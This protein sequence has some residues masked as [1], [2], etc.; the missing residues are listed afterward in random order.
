MVEKLL[1][2]FKISKKEKGSFRY[3]GLNV[4]QMGKE[5]FVDQN[6]YISSLKPVQLSTERVPQ[7]DEE[8]TIEA[9][10]SKLRSISEQLLWVTSQTR[11]HAY[12]DSCRVSNYRGEELTRSK[13]TCEEVTIFNIKIGLLKPRMSESYCVLR[14]DSCKFT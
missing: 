13:Q 3:I 14:C 9:E 1:C 10:K 12:F 11:P 4:A 6:N 2:I 8:L 7:K 5:V